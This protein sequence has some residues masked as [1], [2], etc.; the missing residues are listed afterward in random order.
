M[1]TPARDRAWRPLQ[2]PG[3]IMLTDFYI[4][5]SAMCFTL[6]GL[7]LVV[8]Q[9][10]LSQW[11]G[12]PAQRRRSYGVALHFSLPGI[13]TLLSLVDPQSTVLWRTSYAVVAIGGALVL[14][15]VRGQA[16]HKLGVAAYIAAFAL[17]L[18]I[19]ILA[20]APH[21]IKD[22]GMTVATVRVEAVLLCILVFLGVNV[23]WLLLFDG[24]A[25][26][27]V[28]PG[29]SVTDAS[30]GPAAALGPRSS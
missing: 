25:A 21:I 23:A 16:P 27:A 8:V 29:S 5:F 18:V 19:G 7:W 6:L 30:P 28:S 13:M 10:R 15:A 11:E 20:I 4:S 22:L 26:A 24:G 3:G 12:D 17:Y 9:T 14:A 1:R 2:N